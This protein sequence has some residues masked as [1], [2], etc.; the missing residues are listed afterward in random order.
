MVEVV[1]AGMP[2]PVAEGKRPFMEAAVRTCG[3]YN[4]KTNYISLLW[5]VYPPSMNK[6]KC[7]AAFWGSRALCYMRLSR[8]YLSNGSNASAG[9]AA[10]A[11]RFFVS[12]FSTL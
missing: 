12:W 9:S 10:T 7:P 5:Q 2:D 8:F 11:S 4:S 6:N 3:P 1:G